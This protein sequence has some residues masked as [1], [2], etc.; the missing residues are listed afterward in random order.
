MS[1]AQTM[2]V[3]LAALTGLLLV[4]GAGFSFVGA[5]GLARLPSF[6]ERAH[7]PGLPQTLGAAAIALACMLAPGGD[8]PSSVAHYALIP[9]LLTLAAP[10]TL[11]LLVRAARARQAAKAG[12]GDAQD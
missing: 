10:A 8:G 9:I 1:G 3:W 7:A 5:L 12:D 6:Y 2:P 4:L 11:T